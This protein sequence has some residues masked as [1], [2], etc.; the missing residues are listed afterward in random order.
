MNNIPEVQNQEPQQRLLWARRNLYTTGKRI[1]SAQLILTLAIPILGS[2]LSIWL[3]ALKPY[4]AL[5]SLVIAVLDPTIFDRWQ[6]KIRSQA[7]RLQEQFDCAVLSLPWDEFTAGRREEYETIH[8]LSTSFDPHH[9][10][11]KLLDW[12]PQIVGTV[13][14]HLARII[15]QRTNLWYD[16]KLRR[17]YAGWALALTI[18]LTFLLLGIA[19]YTGLTVESFVVSVLAP[20]SPIIIWGLREHFRQRDTADSLDG[21]RHAA[22]ALWE[23]GRSGACAEE[24]C[25]RQSRQFQDGIFERRSSSPLIFSWI[26]NLRRNTLEQS[27]NKGAEELIREITVNTL[28]T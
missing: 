17:Q 3:T 23:R 20:A 22:E 27:M 13:P 5:V 21:L 14:L 26:Y 4:V 16:G 9:P 7:A 6:K 28:A 8:Q 11:P 18:A 12:Y 24:E 19:I 10:D 1:L 15:C 2:I 25:T